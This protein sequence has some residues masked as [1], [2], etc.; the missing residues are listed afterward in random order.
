M[1]LTS[2]LNQ[3]IKSSNSKQTCIF[4]IMRMDIYEE[5]KNIK[6][7]NKHPWL[8]LH[9][10]AQVALQ[11]IKHNPKDLLIKSS[12]HGTEDKA[13]PVGSTALYSCLS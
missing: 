10:R 5:I 12:N 8:W 11:T 13:T 4:V 3:V 2:Q 1:V 7:K 9:K 6:H